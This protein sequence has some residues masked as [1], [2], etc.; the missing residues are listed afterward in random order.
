METEQF[1]LFHEW[2]KNWEDLA[3]FEI[4]EIGAK[5]AKEGS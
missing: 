5:P 3:R 2:I 1:D 4:T